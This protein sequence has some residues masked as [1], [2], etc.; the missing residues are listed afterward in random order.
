MPIVMSGSTRIYWRSDGDACLPGLVL[1]NSLGTDFS[2][3]DPIIDRLMEHFYVVRYDM[4]GHG[5]SDAPAVDYT[6]DQL[7]DDVQAVIKAARLTT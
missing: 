4:R 2:L 3:W 5:G 1:G 7:T 6:I